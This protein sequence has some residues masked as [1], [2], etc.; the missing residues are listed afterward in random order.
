MPIDPQVDQ[1]NPNKVANYNLAVQFE[2]TYFTLLQQG[3]GELETAQKVRA[4]IQLYYISGATTKATDLSGLAQSAVTANGMIGEPADLINSALDDVIA[5]LA[6]AAAPALPP[7][8][9]DLAVG[10]IAALTV[11]QDAVSAASSALDQASNALA[12]ALVNAQ[13]Q[14]S[15]GG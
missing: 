8:S 14:A 1:S 10:S 6:A 13:A 15:G 3:N 4:A 5:S 11:A 12:Q 9:P 2:E 7:P